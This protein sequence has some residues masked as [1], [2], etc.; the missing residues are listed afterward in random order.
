M[1]VGLVLLAGFATLNVF[2]DIGGEAW[3]PEFSCDEL[4]S[5]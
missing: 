1:S 2:A 3:P 4:A 5:F